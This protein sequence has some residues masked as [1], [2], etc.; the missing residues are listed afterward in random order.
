MAR[1]KKPKA[2]IDPNK[3]RR[4]HSPETI[5]KMSERRRARKVQ[6]RSGTSKK[7]QNLYQELLYEYKELAKKKKGTKGV[8]EAI[9]WL[10]ENKSKLAQ[11]ADETRDM[12]IL[13][14]Y[15]L[16]YPGIYEVRVGNVLYGEKADEGLMVD[17]PWETAEELD[18]S[19]D[20]DD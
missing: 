17:D 1:A 7:R 14:E 6:P 12:G 15:H 9:K 8:A 18:S 5:A 19:E 2:P 3:P 16:Q 11:T 20:F 4:K 10:E 13:C